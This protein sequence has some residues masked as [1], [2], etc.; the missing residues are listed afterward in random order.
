MGAPLQFFQVTESGRITSRFSSD[1]DTIDMAIP[2]ALASFM[3]AF[4]A[5]LGA[6]GVVV[7]TSPCF[8]FFIVPIA[9]AY[10]RIQLTYRLSAK[11]VRISFCHYVLE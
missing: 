9:I 5:L 11:E 3:D 1:F 8:F 7:G 10:H 2:T 4:L 6:V